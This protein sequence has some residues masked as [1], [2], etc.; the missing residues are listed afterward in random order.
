MDVLTKKQRSY[1]MSQIRSKHT[2]IEQKLETIMRPFRLYLRKHQNLPGC[3]DLSNKTRRIAF[4]VDG[5]FW[6]GCPLHYKPPK[7]NRAYWNNK[8]KKNSER[9]ILVSELLATKGYTVIRIWEHE[10]KNPL[11]LLLKVKKKIK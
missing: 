8:I 7:S 5:C 2:K 4:F 6:H 3:P 9:D 11:T 10:L 1:C